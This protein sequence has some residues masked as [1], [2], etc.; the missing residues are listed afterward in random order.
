MK[1]LHFSLELAT[2]LHEILALEVLPI[3]MHERTE[4][5]L[6][7]LTYIPPSDLSLVARMRSVGLPAISLKE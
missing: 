5:L 7:Q 2:H 6:E 1:T 4:E 3:A